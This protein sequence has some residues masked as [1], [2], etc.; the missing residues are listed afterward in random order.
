MQKVLITGIT[1]FTGRYMAEELAANGY[2]VHG[3]SYRP[4]SEKRPVSVTALHCCPLNHKEALRELLLQIRPRF[5][6]HLAAVSFVAHDDVEAIYQANLLGTRHL[7]EALRPLSQDLGAV[8]LASSANVYGNTPG[9]LDESSPLAPTNDYAVSKVAMEYLARL[10]R[11]HLPLIIVRPFNYTGIGQAKHFLVPKIVAHTR[12]RA[13]LI[14]LGNLDVARDFCD[15]RQVVLAYRRLLETQSAIG[16][17]LN[18][19]SGKAY[20]LQYVL[21]Q[22]AEISGH[23]MEVRTNPA[24][25]RQADVKSLFG[26]RDKLVRLIGELEPLE[27]HETLRWMLETPEDPDGPFVAKTRESIE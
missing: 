7:L 9:P 11:E 21:D 8:L 19:C 2:E 16:E 6:I 10:Y 14:E 26:S 1:G 5:V 23:R 13:A 15:V 3:L 4:P 18:V 24:Y 25:V 20:T 17:T 22:A 12:R 27:L